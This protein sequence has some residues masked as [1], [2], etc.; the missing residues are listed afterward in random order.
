MHVA[1]DKIFGREGSNLTIHV[2]ITFPEAALGTKLAVPTVDG[3]PVTIKVPAGTS[4]GKVFRVKGRGI[5]TGKRARG[6]LMVTVDVAVPAKLSKEQRDAVERFAAATDE[7]P[8]S[9]L[10]V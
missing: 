8:R 10:G 1:A 2:P 7:S 6:D 4:S 9:H 5:D 3:D